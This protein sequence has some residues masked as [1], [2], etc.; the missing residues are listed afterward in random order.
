M[1]ID[2]TVVIIVILVAALVGGGT[3][4]ARGLYDLNALAADS[5]RTTERP[6]SV[7]LSLRVKLDEL[8]T[9]YSLT[10][11]NLGEMTS[12]RDR[13]AALYRDLA[14][15]IEAGGKIAVPAVSFDTMAFAGLTIYKE[16]PIAGI[17]A[18][19][20]VVRVSVRATGEYVF[21]PVGH[22]RNVSFELGK[23]WLPTRTFETVRTVILEQQVS[24]PIAWRFGLLLGGSAGREGVSPY[25]M[26]SGVSMFDRLHFGA[27]I[28]KWSAGLAG[29]WNFLLGFSLGAKYRLIDL[30]EGT[31]RWVVTV[32]FS[33][34]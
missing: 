18:I 5:V 15:Q 8:S 34:I 6:D 4:Y 12:E 1:K 24:N 21:P 28:D 7:A 26:V 22:F 25:G 32:G 19:D 13:A 30:R 10:E 3:W 11:I 16:T 9:R 27:G 33:I 20:T 2:W 31:D 17:L 23:V 14:R 29:S